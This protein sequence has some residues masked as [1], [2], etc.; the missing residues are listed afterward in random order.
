MSGPGAALSVTGFAGPEGGTKEYPVGTVFIGCTIKG[1]TPVAK[2]CHLKGDRSSVRED[3]LW[4]RLS[5]CSGR[6]F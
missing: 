5:C 4:P 1:K 2:E 3:R 6:V